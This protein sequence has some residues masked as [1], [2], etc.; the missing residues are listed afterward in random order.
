MPHQRELI[1]AL[2]VLRSQW[3]LHFAKP[4]EYTLV[5]VCAR[6]RTTSY[7]IGGTHL[8]YSLL[9]IHHTACESGYTLYPTPVPYRSPCS[10]SQLLAFATDELS[11]RVGETL[12]GLLNATLVRTQFRLILVRWLTE[13]CVFLQGNASVFSS[14]STTAS[15]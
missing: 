14:A 2:R 10:P 4:H 5:F 6:P 8:Y 1:D 13:T 3:A 15:F 7:V 12:A 11:I 9:P